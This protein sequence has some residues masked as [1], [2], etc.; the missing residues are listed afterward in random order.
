VFWIYTPGCVASMHEKRL[1]HSVFEE[2]RVAVREP[3]LPIDS[4][5]PITSSIEAISPK[6]ALSKLLTP[7]V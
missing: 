7:C 2:V 6:E 5:Y 4:N 3:I 1:D